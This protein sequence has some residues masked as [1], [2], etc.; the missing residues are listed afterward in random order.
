MTVLIH[1][2]YHKTATTW[3]QN[4]L[5]SDPRLFNPLLTHAEI[6]EHLVR[7]HEL[8]FA[9]E[10]PRHLVRSR[11]G[12]V[13][14]A[15]NVLSSEILL[16]NPFF[17]YR[18]TW[19]V[20]QRLHAIA[21]DAKVLL[22]VRNQPAILRSFYQQYLGRGGACS[23][24]RFFHPDAVPG[25]AGFDPV[26]IEYDRFAAC[27]EQTF[28]P[29]RVLVLPQEFLA[30]SRRTFVDAILEFCG[31]PALPAGFEFCTRGSA[32]QSP[33]LGSVPVLRFAN[34]LRRSAL[35]P[36]AS[37]LT[38]RIGDW[39]ARLA[40]RQPL[41]SGR[42]RREIDRAIAPFA[43]R[44]AASNRRLQRYVPVDLG[45]LGYDLAVSEPTLEK[46]A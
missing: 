28:G 45:D 21:P 2:G 5:F 30:R 17:G 32:A 40:W 22:T 8:A 31:V 10:A 19:E 41:F 33:P 12:R 42:Y 3:L 13:P 39:L 27:Y 15:I 44:Y 23:A 4:S 29:G 24:Q 14:G 7:P 25:Y 43:G 20:A 11:C 16:G 1:P 36:G 35:N 46:A 26:T 38:S 34:R 6:D 18:G 37:L 9:A